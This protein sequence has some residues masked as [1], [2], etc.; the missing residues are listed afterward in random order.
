MIQGNQTTLATGGSLWAKDGR[1]GCPN[2]LGPVSVNSLGECFYDRL[3][4]IVQER[5]VCLEAGERGSFQL[6]AFA[7]E[8]LVDKVDDFAVSSISRRRDIVEIG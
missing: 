3:G 1:V 4:D 6:K 7:F 2:E 5:W 8:V